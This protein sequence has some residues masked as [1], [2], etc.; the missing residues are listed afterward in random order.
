M[1]LYGALRSVSANVI[2]DFG[3]NVTF[4]HS[5]S[6]SFDPI[7]GVDTATDSTFTGYGVK[8]IYTTDEVDGV[9]VLKSDFK[10]ILE[11]TT[12]API[13]KDTCTIGTDVYRVMSV[14]AIDP[15]AV[16]IIYEVQLR[17]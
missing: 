15:D 7:L 14:G 2:K 4:T 5:T 17:R 11:K 1:S 8:E 12:T 13:V 3:V 9:N 6:S 10:L 16:A